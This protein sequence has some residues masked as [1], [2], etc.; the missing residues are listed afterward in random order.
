MTSP[1]KLGA[2][3]LAPYLNACSYLLLKV[4]LTT[5]QKVDY[6]NHRINR[7]PENKS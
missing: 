2:T 4:T 5:F 3:L 6:A 7:K 1:L